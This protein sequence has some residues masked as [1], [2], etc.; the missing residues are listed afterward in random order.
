M[1]ADNHPLAGLLAPANLG[2]DVVHDDWSGGNVVV[3]V[4]R[5]AHGSFDEQMPD[6]PRV[7]ATELGGGQ[8]ADIAAE[9]ARSRRQHVGRAIVG[10]ENANGARGPQPLIDMFALLHAGGFIVAIV[11]DDERNAPFQR[12]CAR[13]ASREIG[14]ERHVAGD[15]SVRSRRHP[16]DRRKVQ[17]PLEA[18]R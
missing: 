6:Q 8:H 11:L 12:V 16:A 17:R 18:A 9:S 3:K 5:D 13:S 2:D 7:V 4:E 10:P 1:R 15:A 14:D